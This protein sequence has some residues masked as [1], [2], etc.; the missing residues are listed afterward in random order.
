MA[1]G[2]IKVIVHG[3]LGRMGQEVTAYVSGQPDMEVVGAVDKAA[4][5]DSLTL[6]NGSKVILTNDLDTLLISRRPEVVVDFSV[7]EASISAARSAISKGV[8]IVIGTTGLSGGDV[9]EI[10]DLCRTHSVGGVIAPNFALGAV[11]LIQLAKIASRYFDH[12][13]IVELHHDRKLD[14]PSGT[15]LATAEAMASARKRPFQ[16]TRVQKEPLPGTR[17]GESQGIAIHSIRLPGL[18]AHQ[19][20]ILGGPGQTL[21]L[22]HDTISRECFMPGVAMAIRG[23]TT[24]KGLVYGLENLLEME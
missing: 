1:K 21:T 19:E 15:A 17:G 5:T 4:T 6:A 7:A 8:N 16:H 9:K 14:A 13:E 10:E 2:K 12:A 18:L 22:R 24:R 11:L 3:A 20:V 23:V